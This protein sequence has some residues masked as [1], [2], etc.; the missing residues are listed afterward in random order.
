MGFWRSER[1]AKAVVGVELNPDGVAIAVRQGASGD[2]KLVDF[3]PYEDVH[4]A[5]SER[6][7]QALSPLVVRHKLSGH[8]CNLVLGETDY[9]I[10]L[11]EAPD[12]ADEE[13][14][15]ATRWQIADLIAYPA[16]EVTVEVLRLPQTL[17]QFD[18]PMLYAVVAQKSRIEG[19]A[20]AVRGSRL[21][22]KSVGIRELALR[23]LSLFLDPDTSGFAVVHV[24]LT[25]THI[26][27]FSEGDLCLSRSFLFDARAEADDGASMWAGLLQEI[28]R[29]LEYF[30][31][32]LG[33]VAPPVV[34][35]GGQGV[36]EAGWLA[37]S[38]NDFRQSFTL[39]NP[40]E[41]Y[42]FANAAGAN[43]AG[44]RTFSRY[45]VAMGGALRA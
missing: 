37:D 41:G 43:A 11:T 5:E 28:Q 39:L 24:D 17:K 23:N 44:D 19:L 27:I 9:S 8:D 36:P 7:R 6:L 14:A 18:S 45:L 20:E 40:Q 3:W 1:R 4:A 32:H 38:L 12:V 10:H 16:D 34:Y 13:L 42:T 33:Q 21:K 30:E 2:I 35:L 15:E 25:K 31:R 26:S 29:S 22:L